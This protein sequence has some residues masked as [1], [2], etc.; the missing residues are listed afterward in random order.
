MSEIWSF[1]VTDLRQ[2]AVCPRI[3]YYRYCL[4]HVRPVTALMRAGIESHRDEQD[5]E[6]RRSLRAYGLTQGERFFN[7]YLKSEHLGLRG[8]IDL[9]IVVPDRT[10][11]N[12][13]AIVVE[14]KDSEQAAGPHWKIQMVAY[15]LMIEELWQ[16]PVRR[17]FF[18]TIPKRQAEPITIT[19]RLRQQVTDTLQAMRQ[20]AQ[21]EHMPNPPDKRAHCTIC[22]FR[23][24]CNDVV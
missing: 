3:V 14:Y 8:R 9:V 16:L 6:E 21:N 20:I 7:V 13:E 11:P 4:P 1:E 15:A 2:W 17:G 5:R 24:F 10:T 22:E 12:A 18:Y 19:T 23:R